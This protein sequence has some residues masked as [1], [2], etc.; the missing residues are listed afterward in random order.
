MIL[1]FFDDIGGDH[2]FHVKANN[3]EIMVTSEGYATNANAL[4]GWEDLRRNILSSFHEEELTTEIAMR[5]ER[6]MVS[7]K[8]MADPE[9]R[10]V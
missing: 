6:S 1:E 10:V 3:G 9:R 7:Q 8:A 5:K 2:R 4:R